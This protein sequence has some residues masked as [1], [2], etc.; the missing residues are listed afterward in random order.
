MTNK[1]DSFIE[2]RD[3][4]AGKEISKQSKTIDQVDLDSW[5][6]NNGVKLRGICV[7][8]QAST[9]MHALVAE[10][11][12]EKNELVIQVPEKLFLSEE[13][14]M[15]SELGQWILTSNDVILNNLST[16]KLVLFLIY[17]CFNRKKKSETSFWKPYLDILP[18]DISIP[19]FFH[20]DTLSLLE[21][22]LV[23][24]EMCKAS[25]EIMRQFEHAISCISKYP[26]CPIEKFSFD[27]FLWAWAI[28]MTRQNR[29]PKSP[30]KPNAGGDQLCLVP[31]WDMCNHKPGPVTTFYE[32]S[33]LKSYAMEDTAKGAEFFMSYG[34]RSVSDLF[35]YSGFVSDTPLN[36]VH[37]YVKLELQLGQKKDKFYEQK[38]FILKTLG[39]S[40]FTTL[41]LHSNIYDERNQNLYTFLN[42]Q[43]SD[44]GSEQEWNKRVLEPESMILEH[45]FNFTNPRILKWVSMKCK[46]LLERYS[47]IPLVDASCPQRELEL[48]RKYVKKEREIIEHIYSQI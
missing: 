16:L 30:K 45:P 22:T 18:R 41:P 17:E 35:L 44:N 2:K 11:K 38:K 21:H 19:F 9:G 1:I 36:F 27:Q 10:K 43:F 12:I 25:A 7:K 6:E 31:I 20:P 14:C 40:T 46:L 5:I 42:V 13:N 3:F 28:L 26:G 4:F 24:G 29:V 48:V 34:Y 37:E 39:F 33:C 32:D 15:K 23:Y 8:W 47:D